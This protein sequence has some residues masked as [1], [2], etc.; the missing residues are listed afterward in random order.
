MH[1]LY[2]TVPLTSQAVHFRVSP[3]NPNIGQEKEK[4]T[5]GHDDQKCPINL[6]STFGHDDQ[7]FHYLKTKS[8]FFVLKNTGKI[9]FL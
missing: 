8:L 9:T 2:A 5:S 7:K 4:D 3:K 1:E 6:A